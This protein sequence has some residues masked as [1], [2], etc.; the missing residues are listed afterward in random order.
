MLIVADNNIPYAPQAFAHIGQVRTVT[1]RGLTADQVAGA[2]VLLVRSTVKINRELL[3]QCKP[4]FVGTAT[5][6]TDH[7]DQQLL[8]ARGIPFASA[9]GS[10]ADSVS[11]WW[12]SS[13]LHLG[14][15]NH[16][17]L[18][19]KTVGIVGVGNVGWRIA[20]KARALGMKVLK[21][22]PPLARLRDNS[23]SNFQQLG[24]LLKNSDIISLHTPLTAEGPDKT[25]HLADNDFFAQLKPGAIFVNCSRG[26]VH[27]TSAL[28]A[29]IEN[30]QL[31]ATALDVWEGEPLIEL[32]L[33]EKVQLATPHIAGHSFDG[34]VKGTY[35]LYKETCRLLKIPEQWKPE[36]SLPQPQI[37]ELE[38]DCQGKSIQDVATEACLRLYPVIEDDRAFRKSLNLKKQDRSALF[39]SLRTS[40]PVRR[41]FS[42]TRLTLKRGDEKHR[43]CLAGL[44]FEVRL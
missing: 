10:N 26:K 18:A 25:F 31:A 6:G 38:I 41:E 13:L 5:I 30:G 42:N 32:P 35:M 23:D 15:E 11:E 34:K 19:G 16:W 33:M 8:A 44:G 7:V 1:G 36:D 2:D 20:A 3:A 43:N 40:Y 24:F 37:P 9:P 27:N 17:Q 4:L 14:A 22:D 21:C 12:T 28:L 29:A 39:T